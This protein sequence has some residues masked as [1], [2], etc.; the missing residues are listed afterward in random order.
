MLA[1]MEITLPPWIN[2]ELR[3]NERSEELI[4]VLSQKKSFAFYRTEFHSSVLH[5]ADQKDA[6]FTLGADEVSSAIVDIATGLAVA[7]VLFT[8]C[9]KGGFGALLMASLCS[10]KDSGRQYSSLCFGPQTR[11]HP[12]NPR[13]RFPSYKSLLKKALEDKTIAE[14]LARYGDVTHVPSTTRSTIIFGNLNADDRSEAESVSGENVA[15]VRLHLKTHSVVLP[16]LVDNTDRAAV[17]DIVDS[18]TQ[19]AKKQQDLQSSLRSSAMVD[20]ILTLPRTKSLAT[21]CQE[22]LSGSSAISV[23]SE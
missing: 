10:A 14:A 12:E 20:E 18:V 11:I 2:A 21:L 4:V 15:L 13:V 19:A 22:A 8:G 3:V 23:F 5:L 6:Y 9:S 1:K 16:F 17:I 7:R